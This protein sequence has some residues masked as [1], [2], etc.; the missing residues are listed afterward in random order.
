MPAVSHKQMSGTLPTRKCCAIPVHRFFVWWSSSSCQILRL[1]AWDSKAKLDWDFSHGHLPIGQLI[2]NQLL[3]HSW[4]QSVNPGR[5]TRDH[6]YLFPAQMHAIWRLSSITTCCHC[7]AAAVAS[8]FSSGP[9][10]PDPHSQFA[11]A[12]TIK[13]G[14]SSIACY[15]RRAIC[16]KEV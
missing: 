15:G 8:I 11:N 1:V 5:Q 10:F 16:R 13:D 7:F 2:L 12:R 6:D 14:W 3:G 9:R 4:R